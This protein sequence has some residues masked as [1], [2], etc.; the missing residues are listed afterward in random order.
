M[1]KR[2]AWAK[3]FLAGPLCCL[4]AM[5]EGC[6]VFLTHGP[7]IGHEQMYYFDCTE[8]RTGP[9]LDFAG[10]GFAAASA[11]DL[12]TTGD[13]DTSSDDF[14]TSLA[15]A[16]AVQVVAYTASG[17]LGLRK[18]S[19]CREARGLLADR[20]ATQEFADSIRRS[21]GA[22]SVPSTVHV[23]PDEISLAV[24]ERVQLTATAANSAGAAIPGQFFVWTSSNGQVASVD[25][26][27]LVTAKAEGRVMIAA[28][29]GGVVGVA[30]V[31]VTGCVQL[32]PFHGE[33]NQCWKT[34][35]ESL[36]FHPPDILGTWLGAES[37]GSRRSGG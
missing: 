22:E 35:R 9:L 21:V 13:S 17:F 4:L 25:A 5:T 29:T 11:V 28:N 16:Y 30:E 7:P 8:S 20:L 14:D 36:S 27:G 18:T 31:V 33:G 12:A 10:A 34:Y 24:G 32:A 6:G 37:P 26:S 3:F 15:F 23:E 2:R 1:I 19:R